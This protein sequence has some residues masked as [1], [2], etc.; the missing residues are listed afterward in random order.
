MEE[1]TTKAVDPKAGVEQQA[2][3]DL[4]GFA[5]QCPL[6]GTNETAWLVRRRKVRYQRRATYHY[7][8]NP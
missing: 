7:H 6:V 8:H 1:K 3:R 4:T 5:P 2:Y